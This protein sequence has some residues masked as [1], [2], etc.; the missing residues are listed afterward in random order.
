MLYDII[1][2]QKYSILYNDKVD[3][4]PVQVIKKS[5]QDSPENTQRHIFGQFL[6]ILR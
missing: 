3:T 2:I 5:D 1:T 4:N 6:D